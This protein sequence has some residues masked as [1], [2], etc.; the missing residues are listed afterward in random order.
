MF[1]LKYGWT[2]LIW[3]SYNGYFEAVRYIA[4]SGAQLEATDNVNILFCE[5]FK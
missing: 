5:C 3:A 4:N 2:P 1:L